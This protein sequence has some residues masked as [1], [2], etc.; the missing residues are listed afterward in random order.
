M[1]YIVLIYLN[2]HS[3]GMWVEDVVF[4]RTRVMN[5]VFWQILVLK[6]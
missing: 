5:V 4:K 3:W 1:P 2:Q 6:L